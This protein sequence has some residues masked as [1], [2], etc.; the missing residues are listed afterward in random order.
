M[1]HTI[2]E[3]TKS[4]LKSRVCLPGKTTNALCIEFALTEKLAHKNQIV[5]EIRMQQKRQTR[6]CLGSML[7]QF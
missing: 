5:E 7:Q 6:P 1:A 2:V 4:Q 3:L